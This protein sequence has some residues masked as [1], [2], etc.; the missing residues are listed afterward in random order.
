[1]TANAG[2]TLLTKILDTLKVSRGLFCLEMFEEAELKCLEVLFLIEL[3]DE[4]IDDL[5]LSDLEP[6]RKEALDLKRFSAL[7]YGLCL[8]D[9]GI[10][11]LAAGK[12]QQA[13]ATLTE[14]LAVLETALGSHHQ[15]VVRIF[16][17]L[18]ELD[19]L[20]HPSCDSES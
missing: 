20:Y 8:E 13:E 12:R 1:M 4:Q 7:V 17:R 16:Q 19:H 10:V 6:D 3:I 9:L 11:I 18:H 14:A 5:L 15:H 2:S